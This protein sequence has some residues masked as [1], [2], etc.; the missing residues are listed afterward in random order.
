MRKLLL[1]VLTILI[2][3]TLSFGA[4]SIKTGVVDGLKALNES[5]AGKKAKSDLESMRAAKQAVIDE[6]GKVIEKLRSELE[7]QAS[8]LSAEAKKNKEEELERLIREYQRLVQDS[9]A[10]FKKKRMELEDMIS[11]E[12]FEIVDKIGKEDGYML[13][14]DRNAVLYSDKGIDI[15]DTVIKKYNESKAKPK[16][17]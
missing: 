7:K 11:K 16:D 3:P 5:E 8:V 9:E 10:E 6:K 12:I 15:T 14:L 1:L 17:Q 2:V 4:D 13:I